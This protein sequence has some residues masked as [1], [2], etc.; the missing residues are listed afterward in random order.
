MVTLILTFC[1]DFQPLFPEW[2]RLHKAEPGYANFISFLKFGNRIR[3]LVTQ[4]SVRW[5]K[6]L[7]WVSIYTHL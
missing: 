5:L 6:K 1:A 4:I 3:F 7:D 2:C